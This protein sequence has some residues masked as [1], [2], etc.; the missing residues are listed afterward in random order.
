MMLHAVMAVAGPVL[1]GK[2]AAGTEMKV[3]FLVG[4]VFV[5]A[6]LLASRY[7]VTAMAWAVCW[8]YGLRVIGMT[9]ALM[10]HIELSARY[11]FAALRGG[12]LATL[13]VVAALFI[14]DRS[15]P[16]WSPLLRLAIEIALS[17]M[18][19][20]SFVMGLPRLALSHDLLGVAQKLL[21][22]MPLGG[23]ILVRRILTI[24]PVPSH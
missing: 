19:L 13:L 9:V 20:L 2:G 18:V 5:A 21:S 23:S 15:L 22:R 1:W 24:R 16:E 12:V 8:V 10:R 3:Q 7:S 14:V 6:L 17:G 11:L 4:I